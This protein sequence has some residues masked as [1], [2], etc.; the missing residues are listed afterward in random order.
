MSVG[1]RSAVQVSHV[2][3]QILKCR[4]SGPPAGDG[5][6]D[7]LTVAADGPPDAR[8]LFD[9]AIVHLTDALGRGVRECMDEM[10][11]DNEGA[12]DRWYL[13][14]TC[15]ENGYI[16][17]DDRGKMVRKEVS[18]EYRRGCWTPR[19]YIPMHSH[20]AHHSLCGPDV[21]RLPDFW[22]ELADKLWLGLLTLNWGTDVPLETVVIIQTT[23][24]HDASPACAGMP[25]GCQAVTPSASVIVTAPSAEE[26]ETTNRKLGP[27]LNRALAG[28]RAN[29]AFAM[30]VLSMPKPLGILGWSLLHEK[31]WTKEMSHPQIPMLQMKTS[32]QTLTSCPMPKPQKSIGLCDSP[33]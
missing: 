10:D 14:W 24:G 6:D 21:Q 33:G 13:P 31:G 12:Q 7:S 26:L 15:E 18:V 17:E 5:E 22:R 23:G 28:L 29:A 8:K 20:S 27:L 11:S 16:L 9:K 25:Q 19:R 30:H 1:R 4:L 32:T 3:F 2:S